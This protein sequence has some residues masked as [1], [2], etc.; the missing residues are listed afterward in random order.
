MKSPR[1]V[2]PSINSRLRGNILKV[3]ETVANASGILVYGRKLKSFV[4]TTDPAIF[5]NCDADAVFAV[6]PFT[7]QP[8]IA[9]AVIKTACTPVFCGVGGGTTRGER[10]VAIAKD[11]ES[12]GAMGVVLNSPIPDHDLRAVAQ[13][14]DVPV[15]VTVTS[16][17]TDIS[18]RLA[19]GASVLNIACGPETP[20][21]VRAV[22]AGFPDVP[23]IASGG[24]TAENIRKT[25]D[26]GANA[27]T[28]TPPGTKE[29]FG[30]MMK[31]YRETQT[32]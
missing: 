25:I 18:A 14:V 11:A 8:A 16:V 13:A 12:R 22:R 5:L 26:A 23:I 21:V 2:A 30:I 24:N 20:D 3:P 1:P 32:T 10:T 28:Y 15:V 31:K 7:P 29:L 9:D 19:S 6:Y 4:F 27:V 17:S